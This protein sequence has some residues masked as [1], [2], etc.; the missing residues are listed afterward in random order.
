MQQSENEGRGGAQVLRNCVHFLRRV[1]PQIDCHKVTASVHTS[2]KPF[3][4]RSTASGHIEAHSYSQLSATVHG[5]QEVKVRYFFLSLT[6]GRL[7]A[8]PFYALTYV[9]QCCKCLGGMHNCTQR[10]TSR[11][12]V[13]SDHQKCKTMQ[14]LNR[15]IYRAAVFERLSGT[16]LCQQFIGH[17]SKVTGDPPM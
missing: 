3:H 12:K 16:P 14:F 17:K 2:Q 13:T 5:H 8:K 6:Q 11:S 15:S 10:G 9:L 4:K 7:R 1:H